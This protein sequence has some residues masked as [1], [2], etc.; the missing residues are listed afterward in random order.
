MP[1]TSPEKARAIQWIDDNRQSLS[2][3]HRQ[4]WDYAEPAWREYRSAAAFCDLLE[5]EG[6]DVERGSGQMPT[7]FLATYG[8]GGPVLG[9]YAEYDAVPGNSQQPVPYKAPREGLHPW[10]AGHHRPPLLP[11]ASPPSPASSQPKTPST[12]T[13]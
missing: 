2:D 12:G 13:T 7:A 6:F 9:T 3:F 5:S 1:N 4:I 10:A 8:D 11:R